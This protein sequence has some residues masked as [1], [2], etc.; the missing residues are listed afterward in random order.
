[1]IKEAIILAGGLGTRLKSVIQDIPK[2]MAPVAGKPFLEYLFCFLK[3]QG[4]EKV[5]LS[6]GYKHEVIEAHFGNRWNNL[7]I[8]YV[9]EEKPLGTGGA[10]KLA[11]N[12]TQTDQILILNGDTFFAV[13]LRKFFRFHYEKKA[14]ISIAAKKMDDLSRYGSFTFEDNFRIT[15]FI[16]KKERKNGYI[17]GGIYLIDKN[18]LP[19]DKVPEK[20]SFEKTILME[21]VK[22]LQIFAFPAGNYFIDIGIPEDYDHAQTELPQFFQQHL[23]S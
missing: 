10:I 16:E 23:H 7:Q 9:I 19:L 12:K 20:F 8:E 15:D 21:K 5:I 22:E 13:D 1:M 18:S 2:P 4:I 14:N 11:L 17:N 6:T 3:Q